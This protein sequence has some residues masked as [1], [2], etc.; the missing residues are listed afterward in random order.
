[1]HRN[2]RVTR[3]DTKT[4]ALLVR[5][6]LQRP[7]SA[8]R[9]RRDVRVE[10]E[11][12]RAGRVEEAARQTSVAVERVGRAGLVARRT[13]DVLVRDLFAARRADESDAKERGLLGRVQHVAAREDVILRERRDLAAVLI[14]SAEGRSNHRNPVPPRERLERTFVLR[15]PVWNQMS[16]ALRHRRARG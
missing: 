11:R 1:M 5:T 8:L 12:A 3:R 9:L 14:S 7:T 13:A 2:N 15:R 6:N 16:G 4:D 10:F